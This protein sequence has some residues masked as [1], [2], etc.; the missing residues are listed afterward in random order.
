MENT[1]ELENWPISPK[2]VDIHSKRTEKKNCKF[3][4]RNTLRKRREE[5]LFPF[6]H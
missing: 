5:S 2:K 3:S 4:K 1:S 6:L